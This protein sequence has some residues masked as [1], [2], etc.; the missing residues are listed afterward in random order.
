M[1]DTTTTIKQLKYREYRTPLRLSQCIFGLIYLYLTINN[2]TNATESLL[3]NNKSSNF[4][5]N[6]FYLISLIEGIIY[7]FHLV[8][9]FLSFFLAAIFAEYDETKKKFRLYNNKHGI[10]CL[11]DTLFPIGIPEGISIILTSCWSFNTLV[12]LLFPIANE[13]MLL[14][15]SN[16]YQTIF[17]TII[18]T[19]HSLS[20][21]RFYSL[22]HYLP[23]FLV[24]INNLLWLASSLLIVNDLSV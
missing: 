21:L 5:L 16:K 19:G 1:S 12:A 13:V 23:S 7:R 9:G 4:L 15:S 10:K 2:N 14:D 18:I 20:N 11:M 24:M 17:N 6:P 8:I 3:V 22:I